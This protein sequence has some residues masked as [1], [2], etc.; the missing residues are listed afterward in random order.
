MMVEVEWKKSRASLPS[1]NSTQEHTPHTHKHN[2]EKR[3]MKE[4]ALQ[5]RI[6]KYE[7][8]Y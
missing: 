2:S 7:F 1:I 6:Q 8:N 3:K 4:W 5:T